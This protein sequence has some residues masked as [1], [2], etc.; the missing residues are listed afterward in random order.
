[1]ITEDIQSDESVPVEYEMTAAEL[2]E[3]QQEYNQWSDSSKKQDDD[4]PLY[5]WLR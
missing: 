4:R 3:F 2:L 1:M 5:I